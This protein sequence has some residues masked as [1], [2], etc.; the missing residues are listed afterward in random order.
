[1]R[2]DFTFGQENMG[3][4]DEARTRVHQIH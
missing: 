4:I 2:P 3:F 1:M